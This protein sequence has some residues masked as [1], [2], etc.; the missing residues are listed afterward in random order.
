[1][2]EIVRL[3]CGEKAGGGEAWEYVTCGFTEMS[4]GTGIDTSEC[5]CGCGW[6]E[7]VTHVKVDAGCGLEGVAGGVN[8]GCGCSGASNVHSTTAPSSLGWCIWYWYV[9]RTISEGLVRDVTCCQTTTGTSLS[10]THR[11]GS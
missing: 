5:G 6:G 11:L 9:C 1:V 2:R 4:G 3:C 10:L 8:G 7:A